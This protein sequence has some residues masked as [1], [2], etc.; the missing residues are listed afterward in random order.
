MSRRPSR[1][2]R[3]SRR[4]SLLGRLDTA[5]RVYER[6]PFAPL[7]RL[8]CARAERWIVRRQEAD[9]SWGGIQPPWVYS[10]IALH[11]RG[12]GLDHPVMRRGIEGIEGLWSRTAKDSSRRRCAAGPEQAPGSLPVPGWDTALVVALSDAGLA[13]DHPA[14]VKAVSGPAG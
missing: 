3:R 1:L 13:G 8:A 7:R 11:L 2:E 9:G 4:S 12:Y 5:L 6:H 14:M 10:L